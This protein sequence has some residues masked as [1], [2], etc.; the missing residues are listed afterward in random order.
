MVMVA[1]RVGS[2][3]PP[4]PFDSRTATAV[5]RIGDVTD[6]GINLINT[7]VSV[8]FVNKPT[9]TRL[10]MDSGKRMNLRSIDLI[11]VFTSRNFWSADDKAFSWEAEESFRADAL[12]AGVDDAMAVVVVEDDEDEDSGSFV[13]DE[14]MVGGSSSDNDNDEED[15]ADGDGENKYEVVGMVPMKGEDEAVD[16][17]LATL[18]G[19]DGRRA[20]K[21]A[22]GVADT[23]GDDAE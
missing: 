10:M 20:P 1:S 22:S 18:A 19:E 14:D 5:S 6:C 17:C 9:S 16:D 7:M 3:P 4:S 23:D 13:M 21:P 12:G 15:D 8:S 11:M 2:A